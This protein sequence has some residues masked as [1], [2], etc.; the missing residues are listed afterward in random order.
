M[1]LRSLL[2][3][4]YPRSWR[5]EYGAELAGILAQESL[6]LSVVADV[7]VSAARQHLRR[8]APWKICSLGLA[9]W[10]TCLAIIALERFV[11]FGQFLCCYIVGQLFLS[12]AGAWTALREN[13]GVWRATAA[14]AKAAMLPDAAFVAVYILSLVYRWDTLTAYRGHGPYY[15]ISKTVL[16]TV[17]ASL[18]FGLS[19]A[20]L[21]RMVIR[22]RRLA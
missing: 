5:K 21:A 16:V 1:T 8:D 3:R 4:L 13:S 6:T 15:W 12:A 14:S 20:S 19:G 7:L 11:T 9:L 18:L 2:V 10:T 17:F 22:F